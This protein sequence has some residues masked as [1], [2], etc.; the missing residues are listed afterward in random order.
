MV[1]VKICVVV[2][3]LINFLISI[4]GKCQDKQLFLSTNVL[5]ISFGF[6]FYIKLSFITNNMVSNLISCIH[7]FS[8]ACEVII[9]GNGVNSN[10]G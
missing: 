3:N 5:L 7:N 2:L 6:I 10:L 4:T 8:E 9:I 1:L